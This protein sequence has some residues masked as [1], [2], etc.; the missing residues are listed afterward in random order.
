MITEPR[1]PL[2]NADHARSFNFKDKRKMLKEHQLATNI[3]EQLEN[4]KT[5][6]CTIEDETEAANF[7][8]NVSYFRLIKGFGFTFKNVNSPYNPGTT[9][10]Q[11]KNLYL[12]NAKFRHLIFPEIEKVE[13]NFR[14]RIANYFCCKYGVLGYKKADNFKDKEH[15]QKFLEDINSEIRRNNR[16]PFVKN[17]QTNYKGGELPLYAAIE[18]FSFG[19]L[20]KFYKNMKNCDKKEIAKLYNVSYTY[21]ESWIEHLAYV[22][23]ICAHYGRLYN[24]NLSKTPK[25][26][27]E[28][29]AVSTIRIYATLICLKYLLPDKDHWQRFIEELNGLISYYPCVNISLMGFPSDVDWKKYL[30]DNL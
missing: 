14:C 6:G 5:L 1:T 19:T 18:L 4:L 26:Y 12:F 27:K 3:E 21:L 7:L 9:F 2:N 28:Y 17:F 10:N 24:I 30:L 16:S 29:D 20:S 15:H 23:N 11:I 25:L 8:N 13:I 22:R